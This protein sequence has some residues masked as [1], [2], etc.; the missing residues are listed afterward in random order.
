[1]RRPPVGRDEDECPIGQTD[2]VGQTSDLGRGQKAHL[3]T[4][5]LRQRHPP[6]RRLGDHAGVDRRSHDLAEEL[7]GLLHCRR[8]E[9]PGAQLGDPGAHVSLTDR[10]QGRIAEAR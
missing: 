9:A 10:G 4:L 6:A 7:V 8:R 2:R 1:M 5:D 3:L